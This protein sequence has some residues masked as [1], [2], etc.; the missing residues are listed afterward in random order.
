VIT[1]HIDEQRGWRG[2]EQQASYLVRG[3]AERGHTVILAGRPGGRFLADDHG[4]RGDVAGRVI[5]LVLPFRG[6]ADLGSAARLALAVRRH[7]VDILHAHTSHAHWHACVARA[8]ARRGAVV[9][10]RRVDF[11][12]NDNP[13]TR[14]KYRN[15]DRVVAIS[16]C[17]QDILRDYGVPGG[18]TELIYSAQDPARFDVDPLPREELGVPPDAPLLLCVA[19]LVGHKDHATL[20]RAMPGLLRAVPEARLLL[21]GEGEL[22]QQLERQAADLGLGASV[23]F[24]GN[25]DDVPRLLRAAD[26]LVLPSKME[27]LGSV[28]WEAMACRLPVVACAAGGI[29]EVVADGETGLLVPVG[30]ADALANALARVL[31]DPA[32]AHT[33]GENGRAR[34]Q[35]L[36][37]TDTLVRRYL[38]VYAELLGGPGSTATPGI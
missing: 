26:V 20:L 12:P 32:L 19:A 8:L 18:K 7:R 24:L 1:L 10:T 15:A 17:I 21:A 36:G 38:E 16:K 9:A 13:L 34:F 22:R 5:R 11:P 29:P 27:G 6:E 3:L 4:L 37:T 28:L 30:D 31:A 2:G 25:R 14:W 23:R 35:Q 33:L